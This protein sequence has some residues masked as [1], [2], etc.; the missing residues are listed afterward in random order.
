[1]GR[2]TLTSLRDRLFVDTVRWAPTGLY[3]ALAGRGART[4]LPRPLRAPLYRAFARAVGARIDECGADLA[5]YPSFGDFFARHLREGARPIADAEVVAP[6]DGV[7]ASAGPIAGETIIQAKGIDF[8]VGELV[9]DDRL[10]HALRDGQWA[11]IYLSPRDY[12]RV[13]T[14]V[15]GRLRGYH[16]VPGMRWPVSLPFV[17]RVE[18]LFAVNERV[19]LEL[20]TRWGPA[21]LVMVSAAGVGNM[22]LS[23]LGDGGDDTR[24]WKARAQRHHVP[25]EAEL[26]AGDEVGAFL[27]GSTVVVL[28]PAGAPA[29]EL[30]EGEVVQVGQPLVGREEPRG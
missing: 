16:Y 11:T 21:A 24:A 22:W 30:A 7:V 29:I 12:H 13:H 5:D 6:S 25:A 15:A 18:K 19:V 2:V 10:A 3:S 9:L 26:E 17:R 1:L 8:T 23:H 27:L 20:E 14:P 4:R 28:L